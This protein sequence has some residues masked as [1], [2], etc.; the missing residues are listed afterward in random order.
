MQ[1]FQQISGRQYPYD[2]PTWHHRQSTQL[3]LVHQTRGVYERRLRRDRD[4][5]VCHHLRDAYARQVKADFTHA[6]CGGRGKQGGLQI[7]VAEQAHQ[8]PRCIT[9]R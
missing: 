8:G 5:L 7:A 6:E 4:H 1:G 2:L 9:M 3:A